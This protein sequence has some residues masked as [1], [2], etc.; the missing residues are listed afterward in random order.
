M[1]FV[2]HGLFP[3]RLRLTQLK[4]NQQEHKIFSLV[5][6]RILK[7][8]VVSPRTTSSFLPPPQVMGFP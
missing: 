2:V 6:Q 8:P 3:F 1:P 5:I 4:E 7:V